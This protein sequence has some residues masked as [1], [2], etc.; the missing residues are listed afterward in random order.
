MSDTRVRVWIVVMVLMT[1]GHLTLLARGESFTVT[2]DQPINGSVQ[3]SPALPPD[4]QYPE[5]T[6]VTI[7]ATPDAG[8]A[9]D[10]GYY[11][12]PGRWG[13]MY[14]ESMSNPFTVT[15]N[16]DQRIGASFIAAQALKGFHVLQ[17]VV[18]ARPGVKS[19]K[20]DVYSPDGAS[21]STAWNCGH[22]DQG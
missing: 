21:A 9:F 11:S 2:L 5:G 4:G 8:Y 3:L 18:Y 14:Y 12:V 6:Q 10:S 15:V 20:Y 16:R 17:N 7:T 22:A 19:L 13:A 1:V